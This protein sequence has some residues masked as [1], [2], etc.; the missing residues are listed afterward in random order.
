LRLVIAFLIALATAARADILGTA[1]DPP[2]KIV[3]FEARGKT[4]ITERTL[5]YLSHVEVGDYV[6]DRDRAK[7]EKALIS[8]ELFK[9]AKVTY[10][11]APGGVTVVITLEDRHSWFAAPT[12]ELVSGKRSLGV[13]YLEA[14]LGG[15]NQKMVLYGQIGERDNLIW[16]VFLDENVRGSDVIIRADVYLYSKETDE[17]ENPPDDATSTAILRTAEHNY[18]GGGLLLGW[19]CEWW[20]KTDLRM[21]TAYVYFRDP[22]APDGTE[23][24]A[25]NNDGWDTT[26]QVRFTADARRKEF[27]VYSGLYWQLFG[28]TTIPGLDDYDYSSALLR[29]YYGWLIG[30]GHLFEVRNQLQ[31]GRH[32]PIHEEL[33]TGGKLDLRGYLTDQ[34]RGDVRATLR[35]EYSVPIVNV[36]GFRFRGLAFYDSGYIGY[37]FRDP[38]GRRNYLSTQANNAEWFRNDVGGGI[39]MYI[40]PIVIPVLG[41]DFAYG[42]EGKSTQ[43]VFQV[44][45]LDL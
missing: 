45:F 4:K 19:N 40:G 27:G 25:P 37:Q 36:R 20:C 32:L 3:G 33:V 5:I 2:R 16:G 26:A 34:F 12:F 13:G 31:L 18:L 11:D 22:H 43:V 29:T 35:A 9:K 14:N 8:S 6:R 7:I 1:L 28:E 24:P 15:R 38:S 44:G 17:Y 23:L 41:L 10:E 21:R 42:I 30:H 39:R